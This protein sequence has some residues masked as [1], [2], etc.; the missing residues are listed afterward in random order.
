ML[1]DSTIKEDSK[2]TPI[3]IIGVKRKILFSKLFYQKVDNG[4]IKKNNIQ[5]ETISR[6]EEIFKW[7][8]M[9]FIEK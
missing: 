7:I 4:E 9:Q 6:F 8:E 2:K 3:E 1:L 5:P